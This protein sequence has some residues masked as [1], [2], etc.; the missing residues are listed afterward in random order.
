MAKKP[1]KFPAR[2]PIDVS[3]VAWFYEERGHIK[4]IAEL[5][6][7]TT[8]GGSSYLGTTHTAIPFRLLC[9]VVDRYRRAK[10][11]RSSTTRRSG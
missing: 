6:T 2:Y 5:R 7:T 1:E 3:K 11:A 8:G 10:R 9:R 4:V